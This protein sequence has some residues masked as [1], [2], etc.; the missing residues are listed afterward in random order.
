MRAPPRRGRAEIVLLWTWYRNLMGGRTVVHARVRE[1]L[2]GAGNSQS[3]REESS[4]DRRRWGTR[5]LLRVSSGRPGTVLR[6][7]VGPTAIPP[8]TLPT[9]CL[10]V[11]TGIVGVTVESYCNFLKLPG[12]D[13]KMLVHHLF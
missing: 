3:D 4:T 13:S 1:R 11:S 8:G 10:L 12:S 5:G 7:P 6:R 9:R 2:R